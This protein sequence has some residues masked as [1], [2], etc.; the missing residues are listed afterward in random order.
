[1]NRTEAGAAAGVCAGVERARAALARAGPVLEAV[2]RA[3]E[4][5]PP[6]LPVLEVPHIT[7]GARCPVGSLL[8]FLFVE[9]FQAK[10][11]RIFGGTAP[12]ALFSG[13]VTGPLQVTLL[14]PTLF[15]GKQ[16]PSRE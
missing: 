11:E 8:P 1:M 10:A 15:E 16:G 5:T 9:S 2:R 7:R 6:S 3:R 12:E 14:R 4:A 13:T